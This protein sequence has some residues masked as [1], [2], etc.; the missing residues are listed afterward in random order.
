MWSIIRSFKRTFYIYQKV[1]RK[2]A[3]L[4]NILI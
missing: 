3:L 1:K 4:M 2:A